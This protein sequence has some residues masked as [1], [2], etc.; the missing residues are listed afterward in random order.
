MSR[1]IDYAKVNDELLE[2]Y[3]L[4]S[5]SPDGTITQSLEYDCVH[6]KH[7]AGK[8]RKRAEDIGNIVVEVQEPH[9]VFNPETSEW[10]RRRDPTIVTLLEVWR[11]CLSDPSI[12]VRG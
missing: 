1:K 10:E 2:L 3:R 9:D 12:T 11:G 5:E 7:Y 4:L 8:A 6:T